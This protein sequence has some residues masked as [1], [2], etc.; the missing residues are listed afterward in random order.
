MPEDGPAGVPVVVYVR[1]GAIR[2]ENW[3]W[4]WE[5]KLE[6]VERDGFSGFVHESFFPPPAPT[7]APRM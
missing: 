2:E 1:L 3:K 5:R 6:L 4:E 7:F